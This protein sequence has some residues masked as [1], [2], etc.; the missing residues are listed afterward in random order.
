MEMGKSF[1]TTKNLSKLKGTIMAIL[2]CFILLCGFVYTNERIML[3]KEDFAVEEQILEKIITPEF[4]PQIEPRKKPQI[5]ATEISNDDLKCSPVQNII[6]VKTHKTASSTVQNLMYRYGTKHELTFALPK[7]NGNRFSYPA[8]FSESMVKPIDRKINIITNHLRASDHLKKVIPDA[9]KITI[10][11]SIPSLY[12]SSFGYFNNQV[13][14]FKKAKTY[15]NFAKTPEKFYD[16]GKN[17]NGWELFAKNH[18]A[19]DMGFDNTIDSSDEID[20]F[21]EL[22]EVDYDLII[23]SDYFLESMVLLRK[24]FCWEWEDVF[25]FVTNARS[26]RLVQ[27][28]QTEDG[29]KSWNNFDNRIFNHF[30]TTFWTKVG[31][32]ADFETDKKILEAKLDELTEKC[33][34]GEK[35]CP[36]ND[37]NCQFHPNAG[38]KLKG[39][40]LSD[41][42]KNNE[43]C[44]NMIEQEL[45]FSKRIYKMQWPG[46]NN[47][48]N[49]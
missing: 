32:Y 46:W 35:V 4:E 17:N 21:I 39:F 7:N 47:F 19:F 30:N 15:E 5:D 12:E 28:K 42:G 27:S 36:P 3:E 1:P 43:L 37:A 31:A 26:D 48:Y 40:Q 34:L 45:N 11:R 23:I 25:F 9:K 49:P 6:F 20:K 16:K 41:F 14:A 8:K 10:I 22:M 38:V 2:I 29:I 18:M 44:K 33:V 24:T 13:S